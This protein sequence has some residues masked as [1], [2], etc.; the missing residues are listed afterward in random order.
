MIK[1]KTFNKW[2]NVFLVAGMTIC[3]IIACI[4]N[5]QQTAGS[6]SL[7]IALPPSHG[8]LYSPPWV[9]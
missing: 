7:A 3:L 6:D 1:E 4:Y 2:F 5:L 9:L 8:S